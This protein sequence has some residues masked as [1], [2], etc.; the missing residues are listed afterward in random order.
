MND[1]E[2]RL[3][4]ISSLTGVWNWLTVLPITEFWLQN[5]DMVE[6][7]CN[8]SICPCG[9]KFDIQHSMSCKK[10][11]FTTIDT[12]YWCTRPNSKYDARGVQE[13]QN[14]T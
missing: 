8:L 1:K 3:V 12:T 11:G 6:K 4:D 5:F 9:C 14:W 13:H 7:T 2:K 10:G